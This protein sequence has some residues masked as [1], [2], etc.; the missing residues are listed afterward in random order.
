[1]FAKVR[2]FIYS[3]NQLS[4]NIHVMKNILKRDYGCTSI[5]QYRRNSENLSKR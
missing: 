4:Q 5:L 3:C 2:R 1:M